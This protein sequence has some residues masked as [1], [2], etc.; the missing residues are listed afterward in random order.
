MAT[1]E[2]KS[3]SMDCQPKAVVRARPRPPAFVR[4]PRFIRVRDPQCGYG[5]CAASGFRGHVLMIAS[6]I[7]PSATWA[8]LSVT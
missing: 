6:P 8:S 7:L 3:V 4:A 5:A 2:V 1:R